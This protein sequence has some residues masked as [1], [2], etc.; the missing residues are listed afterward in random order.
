MKKANA[1]SLAPRAKL[2]AMD[3]TRLRMETNC[4]VGTIGKWA[5]GHHVRE[6]THLRLTK[7]CARLGIG[8]L[9]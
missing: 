3:R 2:G 6:A 8:L 9:T 4:D 1:K 5:N 7:A